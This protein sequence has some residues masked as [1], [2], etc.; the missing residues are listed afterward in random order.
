MISISSE[1]TIALPIRPAKKTQ[2]G[3]GVPRPRLRIP[4]SRSTVSRIATLC[5]VAETTARVRIAGT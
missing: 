4:F 2:V 1:I 5:M 3:S